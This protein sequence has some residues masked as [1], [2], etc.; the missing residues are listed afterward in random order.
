MTG[1]IELGEDVEQLTARI[2]KLMNMEL[3]SVVDKKFLDKGK[4][5]QGLRMSG[6][7]GNWDQ[8]RNYV[9]VSTNNDRQYPGLDRIL[10]VSDKD[11][12]FLLR[13]GGGR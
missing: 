6:R 5:E 10:E 8:Y 2:S 3:L 9:V 11:R 13:S 1:Y 7:Y 4:W 12:N